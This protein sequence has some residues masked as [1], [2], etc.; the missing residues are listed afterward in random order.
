MLLRTLAAP[1]GGLVCA[2]ALCALVLHGAWGGGQDTEHA[3]RNTAKEGRPEAAPTAERAS[4]RRIGE[5]VGCEVEVTVDAAELREGACPAKQG[6]Y[7]I[8]TF[9]TDEG[10]RAWLAQ[11]RMY[12]GTYLVGNRW[13]VT[14]Q[15]PES[16][17]PLRREL[18]GAIEVGDAHS[19]HHGGG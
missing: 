17:A 7:R 16:L 10:Q 13:V 6:R 14:A 9:T 4:L 1:Y 18:G 8:A 11:T 3:A 19:G 12:G 2:G 15:T 5:V